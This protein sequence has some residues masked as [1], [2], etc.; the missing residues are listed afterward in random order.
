MGEK[1]P[2]ASPTGTPSV[3]GPSGPR[4]FLHIPKCAGASVTRSVQK[5]LPPR[6]ASPKIQEGLFWMEDWDPGAIDP[7]WRQHMVVEEDEVNELAGYDVVMGHFSLG[8]LRR[9]TA[10]S[11]IATVLREPRARV[12]SHYAYW[13]L[14]SEQPGWRGWSLADFACRPLDGVLD[15]PIVA[16]E[17]DNLICRMLVGDDQRIPLHG[18][19]AP[20]DVPGIASRAIEALDSLG[21]VGVV[22]LGDSLWKGISA[23]FDMSATPIAVNTTAEWQS[24]SSVPGID[25]AISPK[26]LDLIEARTAADSIVYR[27]ALDAAGFELNSE[28]IADAT[29]ANELSRVG[30]STGTSAGLLRQRNGETEEL[31]RRLQAHDVALRRAQEDLARHRAWL[32]GIQGSA[33]WR[34]M[35]PVRVAKQRLRKRTA[36]GS[37]PAGA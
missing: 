14:A 11:L 15:S 13:R 19:I 2:P 6:T 23:F 25:L 26:T 24:S 22:E 33:S 18:F 37:W 31:Q 5:A 30:N 4:C 20:G 7:E 32:E 16:G 28:R 17:M 21:F 9:I 12:L 10:P 36:E 27:H 34:L 29:F 8:L 3:T 1:P 35:A